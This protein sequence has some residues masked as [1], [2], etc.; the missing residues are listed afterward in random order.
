M[1]ATYHETWG[2]YLGWS[3]PF[4]GGF[5]YN[6]RGTIEWGWGYYPNSIYSSGEASNARA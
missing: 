2:V 1:K 4:M 5:L 3:I 6:V